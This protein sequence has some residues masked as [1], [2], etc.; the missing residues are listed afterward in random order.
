MREERQVQLLYFLTDALIYWI[1]LNAVTLTRLDTIYQVDFLMIQR[2]RLLCL[3]GFAVAAIIAGGYQTSAM[4]DRFDAIYVSCIALAA[5]LVYQ[6]TLSALA[7][8]DVRI[9]SRRE[10]LLGNV[11]AGGLLTLWH[12]HA[13][14]L[15]NR[16]G[17]F[18]RYFY[19]VGNEED[20]RRIAQD[21]TKNDAIAAE[22]RYVALPALMDIVERRNRKWDPDTSPYQDAIIALRGK[23]REAL[24]EILG[25]CEEHFGRTFLYPSLNNMLFFD[26]SKLLPIGGIPLVQVASKQINTP[27]VLVKRA[28]DIVCAAVG[29]VLSLIPCLVT[30]LLVKYSSPGGIFF[31]QER[32]GR[33]GRPFKI[34]KFRSMAPA[35]DETQGYQR[36]VNEQHRITGIGRIIRKYR[37]DELPQLINVLKGDMSLVGP[38]PLWDE[39]FQQHGE[40]SPLWERRLAL[41]PGLTSLSH[42]LGDSLGKPGDFLRYYLVYISRL[43]LLVDLIIPIATVRIVLS[44]RGTR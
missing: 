14:R 10:I 28:M 33:N 42:V 30:A 8:V 27:Y 23:E 19:V 11:L 9:I 20:G 5:A 41:R 22:A 43:S 35:E 31:L 16:F 37:I 13:P 7:P 18:R 24:P 26:H 34:I 1:A 12:Y 29:L 32:L 2:D 17:S 21:I 3:L 38:R 4:S 25:F 39:F 40:T 15:T 36:A 6:F 44:G